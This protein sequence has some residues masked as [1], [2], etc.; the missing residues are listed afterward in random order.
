MVGARPWAAAERPSP[1][2][3]RSAALC[4]AHAVGFVVGLAAGGLAARDN[5]SL[6]DPG[7]A[8]WVRVGLG[9]FY[10]LLFVPVGLGGL[11]LV[12]AFARVGR[13]A[14]P[15]EVGPEPEA[16]EEVEPDE[17]RAQAEGGDAP[18]GGRWPFST[19]TTVAVTGFASFVLAQLFAVRSGVPEGSV[20]ALSISFAALAGGM[21]VAACVVT[22]EQAQ[23]LIG[24]WRW[25]WPMALVFTG[26][27]FLLLGLGRSEVQPRAGVAA[28]A[29][30]GAARVGVG[31]DDTLEA[32]PDPRPRRVLV[33]AVD[34]ADWRRIDPLLAAGEL[35]S[36]RSLLARG[37]RTPLRSRTPGW[38]T[39][40]W[41]TL[42]TGVEP[43][44]HGV[45]DVT[46]IEVPGFTRG[47]QRL[48]AKRGQEALLPPAVG[49]RA[50]VDRALDLGAFPEH[51]LGSRQRRAKAVWNVLGE[52]G[53]PVAVVRW[54]ASFPAEA[55][56][57]WVVANDDPWTGDMVIQRA[58]EEGGPGD[59]IAWPPELRY[60]LA[61]L[62]DRARRAEDFRLIG[63]PDPNAPPT[64]ALL[65]LPVFANLEPGEA[66]KLEEDPRLAEEVR[67]VLAADVFAVTAA[68]RLWR[69]KEP[70][71]LLVQLRAIDVLGHRVGRFPSVIDGAY[72]FLDQA[73]AAF[74]GTV[75]TDTTVVFVSAYGW[76][77]AVD[78]RGH[79]HAPD[80][81]LALAGPAVRAGVEFDESPEIYDVAPTLLA[82]YGLPP[83]QEMP[84]RALVEA[85][86][87]SARP[88]HQDRPRSYG[89]YHFQRAGVVREELYPL[90]PAPA[91]AGPSVSPVPKSDASAADG[92]GL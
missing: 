37:V 38:P 57:G 77:Y 78:V 75:G 1:T 7:D 41:T 65:D 5:P 30:L 85:L 80:G 89:A 51:P 21:V 26:G 55:L 59:E 47:L 32:L 40:A 45:R 24:L 90:G 71:L 42:A 62:I 86:D 61:D 81:V 3:D 6:R 25:F 46:E 49:L 60:E 67:L 91:A 44:R 12:R 27:S 33:V 14:P 36:L 84:G 31:L 18:D 72:R 19:H 52:R 68:L 58:W 28:D 43:W 63:R 23:A 56:H 53:V 79:D 66:A 39:T 82:L 16:G 20:L 73:L 10:A 34:G 4:A 15:P 35:P 22:R 92:E 88:A 17:E 48:Y 74:L 83:S 87:V 70:Q 64:R 50:L 8:S 11:A 13:V 76:D 9:V 2:S 29:V 54:P 69:L